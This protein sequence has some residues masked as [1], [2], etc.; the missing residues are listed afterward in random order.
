MV[1]RKA[2]VFVSMLQVNE[3]KWNFEGPRSEYQ[4]SVL[5]LYREMKDKNI[6]QKI[7]EIARDLVSY[8]NGFDHAWTK[9]PKA[10]GD[11][12]DK[13]KHF[14]EQLKTIVNSMAHEGFF[15]KTEPG[16]PAS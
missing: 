5:P 11:I 14:F 10:A 3:Q 13:G 1:T 4:Q 9:S 15:E 7:K 2:E 6:L 8:R 16:S 12:E